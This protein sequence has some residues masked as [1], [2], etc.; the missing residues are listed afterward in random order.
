VWYGKFCI[1]VNYLHPDGE[2]RIAVDVHHGRQLQLFPQLEY[3]AH[4]LAILLMSAKL[5]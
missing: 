1:L 2:A 5:L 4:V 3:F